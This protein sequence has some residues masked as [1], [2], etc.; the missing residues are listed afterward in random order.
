MREW[1]KRQTGDFLNRIEQ[2]PDV[3]NVM[4]IEKLVA[5]LFLTFILLVACFNIVGSV[6]MLIID[7]RTD[8][9]TLRHLGASPHMVFRV[10]LYEGRCIALLGAVIGLAFGL[11]LCWLQQTFGL[12]RLGGS[13]GDFII[14]AYP[15]SVHALDILVVA[16]TVVAVGFVSVWFPVWY[17]VRRLL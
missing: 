7:K 5:Y 16:L 8:M 4:K 12:I 2:Q 13:S 15:V 14:D 10:F 17:L 6:S 3:F 11:L 9:Q 1:G